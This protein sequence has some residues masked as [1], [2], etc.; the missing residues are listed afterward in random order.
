ART[1]E[2]ISWGKISTSGKHV[3]VYSDATVVLPII[4]VYLISKKRE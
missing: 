4:A 3:V 1:K 2:A